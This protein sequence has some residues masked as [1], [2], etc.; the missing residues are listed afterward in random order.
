[1]KR[2]KSVVSILPLRLARFGCSVNVDLNGVFVS[3]FFILTTRCLILR[4]LWSVIIRA[5]FSENDAV[6]VRIFRIDR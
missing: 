4:V 5:L 1:M 3:F 6:R 2:C